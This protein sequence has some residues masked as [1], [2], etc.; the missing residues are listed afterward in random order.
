MANSIE[1]IEHVRYLPAADGFDGVCDDFEAAPRVRI[2]YSTDMD[3]FEPAIVS[4]MSALEGT[5]RPVTV[6]FIGYDLTGEALRWLEAA[7]RRSGQAELHLYNAHPEFFGGRSVYGFPRV[8]M[9]ILHIPKLL[10]RR[11]VY[12]DTDTLVQGDIGS[13][14]DAELQGRCIGAVRDYGTLKAI[15]ERLPEDRGDWVVREKDLNDGEP[16][17]QPAVRQADG[18]DARLPL[19]LKSGAAPGG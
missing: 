12:L 14:F 5:R 16:A 6:H 7:V 15:V 19:R 9:A 2:A 17:A 3:G 8:V 13:L 4:M 10:D 18:R 11:V 1:H